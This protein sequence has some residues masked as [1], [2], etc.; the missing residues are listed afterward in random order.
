MSSKQ[1]SAI[2]P[3]Q[4]TIKC[5]G[6]DAEFDVNWF[7]KHCSAS[8]CNACKTRHKTDRFLGRH[9]IVSRTG[10]VI[11][12][13]DSSKVNELCAEHPDKEITVYCN[14]CG[15]PSCSSCLTEKHRRHDVIAIEMKYVEC[16][17]KLNDAVID[18]KKNVIGHLQ[19]SITDLRRTL[20]LSES[21]FE[22]VQSEVNKFRQELKD[23]V[24]KSCDKL[25]FELEEKEIEQKTDISQIIKDVE[26]KISANEHFMSLSA[27]K[28]S[29][30]GIALIEFCKLP[31]PSTTQTVPN[32]SKRTPKFVRGE[33]LVQT[34]VQNLGEIRWDG[35][36]T[37]RGIDIATS[38]RISPTP[39]KGKDIKVVSSNTEDVRDGDKNQTDK[40]NP[41]I[42]KPITDIKVINAFEAEILGTSVIPSGKGTAWISSEGIDTMYMYD[43]RGRKVKSVTARK[44]SGIWDIAVN[45]S[46]DIIVCNEDNKVRLVT[47]K[48]KV[49]TLIDTD[50]FLPQGVCQTE[51]EEIVV[52]MAGQGD[53]NHVSV[54][55]PDGER[56]VRDIVVK[57]TK[58][59]QLLNDPYRVV[60]N[61]EDISVLNLG[62][63]VM[64]V[65]QDGKV[66]WVYDGSQSKF[67]NVDALGMCIDKFRNLLISDWN[68]HCVHYVDTEG[69]L[70]QMLLTRDQHGIEMPWGIGVDN[71]TGRVWVRTSDTRIMAIEYFRE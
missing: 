71:E 45:R 23:N 52:C 65:G 16:E 56:K 44:G 48:G 26:T 36:G 18:I 11:R 12:A 33:N 69:G 47:V 41:T 38:T 27:D 24:D 17:D 19:S 70:I 43:D 58:G 34:I 68:N 2:P 66:R 13:H 1:P 54:Y 63:N 32:I 57:D 5:A 3:A 30:G 64:T 61:G 51:R 10:S 6:C 39:Y 7:C 37:I 55:S 59:K 28:I 8:L 46:G 29:K 20:K 62:S 42:M 14:D 49:S 60:K 21:M 35:N 9:K 4:T 67:G 15:D 50:P 22:E 53:R 31:V 25:I 40:G